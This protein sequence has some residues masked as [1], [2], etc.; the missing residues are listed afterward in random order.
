MSVKTHSFRGGMR[1]NSIYV[2]T[3]YLFVPADGGEFTPVETDT[4]V[5]KLPRGRGQ[6]LGWNW[7]RVWSAK[8]EPPIACDG[9]DIRRSAFGMKET[10]L[11]E[12]EN[13]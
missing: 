13:S 5:T 3:T 8:Q 11:L 4:S 6:L 12:R 9:E 2:P 1:A 10:P 7:D